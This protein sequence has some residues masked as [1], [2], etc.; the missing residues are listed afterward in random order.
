MADIFNFQPALWSSSDANRESFI[1]KCRSELSVFGANLDWDAVVWPS[2]AVFSKLG[3]TTRKPSPDQIMGSDF[4]DFAKAYFRYQQG[5]NPTGTKNELKALRAVELALTQVTGEA[6]VARVS[7]T[8]LDEAAMLAKQHYSQG[9]A[10]QCGREIERMA[11]FLS[12]N[13]LIATSLTGWRNPIKRAADRNKTGREGR[14]N[15]EKKLPHP[16]ALDALAEIFASNPSSQ[17]DVF[18]TATFAMLMSAP[19]RISEVLALPVDCEVFENDRGGVERYGWRFYAGKGFEADIKWI[20]SVMVSVAREAVRRVTELSRHARKL[21]I[22]I[23]R[24]PSK[25]YRHS[26]CPKAGE[27]EPLTMVQACKALGLACE[28]RAECHTSLGNRGLAAKDNVHT[29]ETLWEH[30]LARL[31]PEFP[32]YDREKNIKFSNALFTL[33]KHQFHGNRTCSPVELLKP[34]NNYFNNDLSRRA[35]LSEGSHRSIFDRHGY[36]SDSGGRL[37][38]TSHQARHLLNTIAQ[39]GGLSNLEIAK[40]SGRADVKQNRTY[41]HMSEREMVGLA[42]K[43][44]PSKSLFGPVGEVSNHSPIS[45]FEFNTLEQAAAHVTEYGYCV[46]DYTISPCSKY[47]DCVNCTE[48]VCIKGNSAKLANIKIRL[49]KSERL[50]LQAQ[51]AVQQGEMGADRW[52]QYHEK[53]VARLRE[54]VAVLENPNIA[55]GAQIKLKGNDSS[56]LRRVVIKKAEAAAERNNDDLAVLADLKDLLGGGGVG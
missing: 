11:T 41:N 4:I 48:Q 8:V 7:V 32:W 35:S 2:F 30:V 19:S 24:D 49:E 37:S 6:D 33:N 36:S 40:W 54:L 25:F 16:L 44:D 13:T 5:H 45:M 23:E 55:D 51:E 46:H 34:T 50:F 18:T 26:N 14:A 17:R 22:W 53:T 3:V 31:P 15:R 42:E 27:R 12:E 21:A 29:L 52:Y 1:R 43:I 10:Y 39:R 47:R 28:T 56:Q 38:M 9:A 20:P